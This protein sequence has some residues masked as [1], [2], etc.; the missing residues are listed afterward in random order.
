MNA[1]KLQSR[2]NPEIYYEII[3]PFLEKQI[4]ICETEQ[5]I[6]LD[7]DTWNQIAHSLVCCGLAKSDLAKKILALLGED[8]EKARNSRTYKISA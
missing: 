2:F 5:D 6:T 1:W 7:F 3:L 4:Q 8:S